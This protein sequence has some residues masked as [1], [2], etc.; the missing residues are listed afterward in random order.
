MI[1]GTTYIASNSRNKHLSRTTALIWL[2][3]ILILGIVCGSALRSISIYNAVKNSFCT[4]NDEIYQTI[5]ANLNT[6][7]TNFFPPNKTS[8]KNYLYFTTPNGERY[9]AIG[10]EPGRFFVVTEDDSPH[11]YLNA[12]GYL[13]S[14]SDPNQNWSEYKFT[15]LGENLFCYESKL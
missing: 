5:H 2:V 9:T 11:T 3:G 13:Y 12:K 4:L 1:D 6:W 14:P 7:I 15:P 10:M 8:S